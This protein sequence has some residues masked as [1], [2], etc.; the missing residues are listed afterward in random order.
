MNYRSRVLASGKREGIDDSAWLQQ[1]QRE[2]AQFGV[3]EFDVDFPH[4]G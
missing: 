1:G 2:P 4:C 3:Q